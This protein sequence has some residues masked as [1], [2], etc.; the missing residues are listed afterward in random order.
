MAF[1][2][3]MLDAGPFA[4]QAAINVVANLLLAA[5]GMVSG[6]VAAR[7]LGPGGRGELAAIQTW[8]TFLA[9]LAMV[10]LPDAAAYYSAREPSNA[11][12]YLGSAMLLAFMFAVPFMLLGYVVVPVM[13]HAQSASI[14]RASRWYLLLVPIF[15]LIGIPRYPLQGRSDFVPWN[16]MRIAPNLLWIGVLGLAWYLG[17]A[18]PRFVATA[19]LIALILLFIPFAII[20]WRRIPGPFTPNPH[21][22][23]S[24]LRFGLPCMMTMA[25]Q[26]LN[27]R[28]DQ[29]L[30]AAL[31]PPRD[32]GLYVVA[33]AWSGA[34]APLLGAI[35]AMTMPA[36]A[37]A[38]DHEQRVRRFAV[39][40]RIA[41]TL[42]LMVCVGLTAITPLAIILLFGTAFKASIPA[43]MVLMPAAAVLGLNAVL[44]EGLRGLGRP[45]PVL[46]AELAGLATTAIGLA[47]MLRPMEIMGAAIAS[48]LGYSTVTGTLLYSA[49][50]YTG[51]SP[52]DLLVS[53]MAEFR[54]RFG[55]RAIRISEPAVSVD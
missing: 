27:A 49:W 33:V 8:P 25:P 15:I 4:G 50:R 9:G 32:L 44:E 38:V 11:G 24:M 45:Y 16:A 43:A 41:T 51:A 52:K 5:L 10:G 20:V 21:K 40:S 6:I 46:Q 55:A 1:V 35:S 54:L 39:A 30:M 13:L 36:V 12:R 7:L 14:V 29:M 19:N 23:P 3:R 53:S 42:A 17:R 18:V 47:V 28:L 26:V 48:L 37:S 2:R 31:L 22:W 34:V